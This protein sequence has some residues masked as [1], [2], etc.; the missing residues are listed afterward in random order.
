MIEDN[1]IKTVEHFKDKLR[2][3]IEEQE[4]SLS[5]L[6]ST[7]RILTFQVADILDL[8]QL[9]NGVFRKN[10]QNFSIIKCN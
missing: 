9:K 1:K 4:Q 6:I 2:N 8:S 5:V 10:R 3:I 7:E